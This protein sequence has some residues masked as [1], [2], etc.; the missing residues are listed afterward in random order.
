[1]PTM[2]WVLPV[3]QSKS[4]HKAGVIAAQGADAVAKVKFAQVFLMMYP[5]FL[6]HLAAGQQN[7]SKV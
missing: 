6:L 1:M 2:C 3:S 4:S 7:N 5:E